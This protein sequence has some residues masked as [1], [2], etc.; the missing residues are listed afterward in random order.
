MSQTDRY[1]LDAGFS[2]PVGRAR[3]SHLERDVMVKRGWAN[4]DRSRLQSQIAKLSAAQSR[5]LADVYDILSFPDG[6]LAIVEES[7]DGQTLVQW[8][9]PGPTDEGYVLRTLLQIANALLALESAGFDAASLGAEQW[10]FDCEGILNLSLYPLTEAGVLEPRIGPTNLLPELSGHAKELALRYTQAAAKPFIAMSDPMLTGIF[11]G[12]P[13]SRY[14]IA[15]YRKRIHAHCLR[16]RHRA[17]AVYR[18]QPTELN[19]AQRRLQLAHPTAGVATIVLCYDGL[20]FSVH[21][22]VGEVYRN[23]L[24]IPPDS[25]I[26]GSCV[27]TLGASTR[28]WS[29]RYFVTLDITHPEV[30]F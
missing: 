20:Q 18:G 5:H 21:E 15:Q 11:N 22:C 28:P 3:D 10:R 9:D 19:R 1:V 27:I 6:T 24:P 23:N 17:V 7:V 2:G 26:D 13:E 8:M 16:D 12:K 29:E 14:S 30:V 4:Q 25:V